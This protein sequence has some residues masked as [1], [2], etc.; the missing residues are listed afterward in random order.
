MLFGIGIDQIELERIERANARSAHFAK[1]VLTPAEY[2][3]FQT[4]SSKRAIEYLAGRFSAKEAFSKAFATGIGSQVHFQDLTLLN[5]ALG[6]PYFAKYP[7]QHE[8]RA[9]VS[10][11]H[12]QT[13]ATTIVQ[14]EQIEG[15]QAMVEGTHRPTVAHVDLGA[16]KANL[17]TAKQLQPGKQIFA[18]VKANAY[19]HGLVPV[20]QAA[21]EAGVSGFC[22]AIIDEGVALRQAG[23]TEPILVLGVNYATEA[24]YMAHHNLTATV[25]SVDFL[26]AA[27]P[28]LAAANV[29]LPVYLALDSGMGRL[30]FTDPQAVS[31]ACAFLAQHSDQFELVGVFT[32]FATADSADTTYFEHQVAQFKELLAA[33]TPKPPVISVDNTA[34]A[35]WHP[36]IGGTAVRFGIGLYGLNPSGTDLKLPQ[37]LRR[38]LT[39]KSALAFVKQVPKASGIGYGKTYTTKESEWIGTVP[40]G[41]ADGWRRNLQGFT[42]KV[43]DAMCPIVG[44]ICMDQFMVRLPHKMAVGTPV[45]L[46]GDGITAE[47]VATAAGTINY[48]VLTSI[49]SR[50]ARKYHD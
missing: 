38:A 27:A 18:V 46:I 39:W 9:L 37:P 29:K 34:A 45:T 7:R 26:R 30:G 50:V 12:T 16:I 42:V 35:L 8:L 49:S 15:E 47:Q 20:A 10:L 36:E 19:G 41:Y 32:H 23:L 33:V 4:L 28:E 13:A 44:R 48:E 40:C 25:G 1:R 24:V 6:K 14:L 5:D 11:T 2:A 17:A 3:H 43:G 31:R 21:H 22:V